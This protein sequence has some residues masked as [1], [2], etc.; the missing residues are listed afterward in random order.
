MRKDATELL[1][2]I[3][4]LVGL[5]AVAI[6]LVGTWQNRQAVAR[7]AVQIA[8]QRRDIEAQAKALRELKG[9]A[10]ATFGNLTIDEP[11]EGSSIGADVPGMH[12]T[13]TG[14]IPETYKLWIVVRD[15]YNYFLMYPPAEVTPAMGKWSQTNVRLGTPGRW[16]LHVC[17]A[18][19]TASEWFQKKADSNDWSGFATLPKGAE[20]VRYVTVNRK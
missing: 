20:T 13:F 19:K 15:Q 7:Q 2:L 8:G 11:A 5:V 9:T 16:E 4:A 3:A 12:G 17:L 1:A 18:D 14:D 6:S 10:I